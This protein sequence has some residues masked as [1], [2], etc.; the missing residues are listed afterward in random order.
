MTE[1]EVQRKAAIEELAQVDE[2]ELQQSPDLLDFLPIGDI[3]PPTKPTPALHR[4]F[5]SLRLQLHYDQH[6]NRVRCR[7]ALRSESI[8]AVLAASAEVVGSVVD[9][10]CAP[11][12]AR[13]ASATRELTVEGTFQTQDS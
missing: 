8:D 6:T 7:I 1:I 11:G 9:V 3:V 2:R 5:E 12:G 13:K 10:F 4:L